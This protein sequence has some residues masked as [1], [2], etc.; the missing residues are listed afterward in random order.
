MT[1]AERYPLSVLEACA[2]LEGARGRGVRLTWAVLALAFVTSQ[3]HRWGTSHLF[4]GVGAVAMSE[5]RFI[6]C[7]R[8]VAMN[9]SR[10]SALGYRSGTVCLA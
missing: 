4:A 10:F 3:K 9:P 8:L 2:R 1:V 7:N 6:G 5:R